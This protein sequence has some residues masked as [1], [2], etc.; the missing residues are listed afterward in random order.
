MEIARNVYLNRLIS[1]KHN[2][3]IKVITGI[4]RSGKSYLLFKLFKNLLM[5]EGVKDEQIICISLDDIESIKY[6]DPYKL[7]EYICSHLKNDILQY[8]I[9]LDE[10]QYAISK[11]ELKE[12][13]HGVRLYS[14]LNSLLKRENVDVYVTGSNSKLLSSDIMTEFRGRGDEIHIAP[15]S[16]SE[17]YPAHK[18]SKSEAWRDYTYYGGLPHIL[19]ESDDAAKI[20]Y[21]N[22][23]NT[24][25]YLKD[26][27]ER[28]NV[29]NVPAMEA[30]MR[31]IASSIGSLS[32]P[33]KISDTFKSTGQSD[34]SAPTISNY[35]KYLQDAFII[36]KAE[37]YDIKGRKYIST[38]FKYYYT[39]IGLRNALLNFR[40]YEETHI[41]ENIIYNELRFRGYNVD[42]GVVKTH[43]NK[44]GNIQKKQL[45]VDFVANLGSERYYIQSAFSIP[46]AEKLNQEQASLTSISDSFKKIILVKDDIHLWRTE[47]G[48]TIMNIYDFLLDENSLKI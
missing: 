2:N 34:I 8:Y 27:S 43:S 20:R 12:P 21:L 42:V 41:M 48:I 29:T 7:Y 10:V 40:Q 17:Y 47:T 3:M 11:E 31:T 14:V 22:R 36:E 45:E 4:R 24:E 37:R 18:G 1:R 23:M 35:L 6:R 19:S 15:L 25:I 28:Y 5:H 39:D 26:I 46:D 16:F 13:E 30:L 9:F 38:P 44:N 33:Q 32:N